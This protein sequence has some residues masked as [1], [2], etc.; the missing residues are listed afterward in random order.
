M[1]I[2]LTRL[3]ADLLKLQAFM[4]DFAAALR[5]PCPPSLPISWPEQLQSGAPVH[6]TEKVI[7]DVSRVFEIET[8]FIVF[9]GVV[10][11]TFGKLPKTQ[12]SAKRVNVVR[13]GYLAVTCRHCPLRLLIVLRPRL[14][15]IL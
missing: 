9:P 4:F 8:T 10:L 13:V 1:R 12:T 2:G 6:K 5:T 7:D 14:L 11:A 15:T 3:Q